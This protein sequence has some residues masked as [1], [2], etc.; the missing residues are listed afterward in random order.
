MGLFDFFKK[1]KDEP[2]MV[3]TSKPSQPSAPTPSAP[4]PSPSAST[5]SNMFSKAELENLIQILS[6][7]SYIFQSSDRLVGGRNQTMMSRT[8][9]YAGILGYFY[10][11]EYKYGKMADI[12]DSKIAQ[13]FTL[14]M[15]SM[16][17]ANHKKK[18][19]AELADNWSD[20]LQVIFNLQLD[21]NSAG[22]KLKNMESEIQK[23]TSAFEKLLGS[24]CRKPKN[25]LQEMRSA[26]EDR[27]AQM[28]KSAT[29]NP[30]KITCEPHLQ[31]TQQVPNLRDV[32]AKEL[33]ELYAKLNAMGEASQK[34]LISMAS[35]YAFNLVESYYNNAGYVPKNSLDQILEQVFEA[36][37]KTGFRTAFSNLD[38]FKYNCYYGYL[39]R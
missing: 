22:N 3:T 4:K 32:F 24:K 25:P 26:T 1:K 21:S 18:V 36:M 28:V 14:V 30:F 33:G 7:I 31:N 17:D 11:V 29:F 19:V 35:G 38:D 20:V 6:K 34:N 27:Y 23:V 5:S 10:E 16:L 15:V 2:R 9:S 12:V 37:Q 13:H 8:H 39:N